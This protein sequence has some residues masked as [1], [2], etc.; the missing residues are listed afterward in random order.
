MPSISMSLNI[1]KT[2]KIPRQ[3]YC[4]DEVPDDIKLVTGQNGKINHNYKI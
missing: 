2:T 4:G 1:T 3:N